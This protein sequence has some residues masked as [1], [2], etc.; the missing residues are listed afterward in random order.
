[1][2]VMDTLFAKVAVTLLAAFILKVQEP[3]PAQL[4]LHPV[5]LEPEAGMAVSVTV[6]PLAKGSWQSTPQ[7]TPVGLLLTVPLP[8]PAF[9]TLN[10]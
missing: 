7:D 3:V 8:A 9:D 1:M 10:M 4:P 5:N 6:L 2:G